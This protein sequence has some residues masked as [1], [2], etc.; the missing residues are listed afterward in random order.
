MI[1][2]NI[3]VRRVLGRTEVSPR[4]CPP[5]IGGRKTQRA[6]SP[7]AYGAFPDELNT[8]ARQREAGA[9]HQRRTR[10]TRHSACPPKAFPLGLPEDRGGTHR[11]NH[12]VSYS[13][14]SCR[15]AT[16]CTNRLAP[17]P[18]TS[19]AGLLIMLRLFA[20]PPTGWESRCRRS[21]NPGDL[22]PV[23]AGRVLCMRRTRSYRHGLQTAPL[24]LWQIGF[25]LQARRR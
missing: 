6:D 13:A 23:Q 4:R 16:V 21:A 11:V 7:T 9:Y 1:E 24:S 17:P 20:P 19:R 5:R 22:L 14:L 8:R 18:T 3:P 10:R 12:R 2:T 25:L 15:Q